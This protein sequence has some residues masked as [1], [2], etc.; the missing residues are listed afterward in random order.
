MQSPGHQSSEATWIIYNV[1][2]VTSLFGKEFRGP[3]VWKNYQHL[4]EIGIKIHP[5]YEEQ[6]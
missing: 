2:E 1:S 3:M 4:Y 5:V 6:N